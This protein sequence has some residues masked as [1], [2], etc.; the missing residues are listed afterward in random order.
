MLSEF[1]TQGDKR[2]IFKRVPPE[3]IL[4]NPEG[5]PRKNLKQKDIDKLCDSIIASDGILVPLVVFPAHEKNTY[6]LLDGERRLIA[7]RKLGLKEVPV[8]I[9]PKELASAENLATMFTIHMAR[10][11]WNTMARAMAL[12]QFLKLK[13]DLEKDKK[14]LRHITGMSA[15]EINNAML[16]RMFPNE[17]QLRAVYSDRPNGLEPSYLIELAKVIK[18]AEEMGISK[19]EDRQKVV[20]YLVSKIGKVVRDPYQIK[21]LGNILGNISKEEAKN[22]FETLVK[23]PEQS[24]S[25]YILEYQN[26]VSNLRSIH[27]PKHE[28]STEDALTTA[29]IQWQGLLISLATLREARLS[30]SELEELSKLLDQTQMAVKKLS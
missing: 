21:D 6:F 23:N 28:C 8:N 19:I 17:L 13:P 24:I 9:L 5:N 29:K 25:Q 30:K 10:V 3:S 16:I 18:K 22:I 26:K 11:P 14:R 27:V 1:A 2:V 12:N 20:R 4:P 7:A 15:Y